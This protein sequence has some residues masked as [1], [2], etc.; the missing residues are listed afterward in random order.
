M[1]RFWQISKFCKVKV[2]LASYRIVVKCDLGLFLFFRS[3]TESLAVLSEDAVAREKRRSLISLQS[4]FMGWLYE[5]VAVILTFF[6]PLLQYIGVPNVHFIDAIS[7]FVI[8]PLAHLMNDNETKKIIFD[9]N[10]YQGL[11]YTLGLYIQP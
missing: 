6:T 1:L 5:L 2:I 3:H 7:M 4:I 9:E 8:I 10:F 11:R